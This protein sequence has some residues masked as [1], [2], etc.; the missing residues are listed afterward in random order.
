LRLLPSHRNLFS[1]NGTGI[2]P[3]Q[4]AQVD[5]TDFPAPLHSN[6]A[7]NLPKPSPDA[8][9]YWRSVDASGTSLSS[10][11]SFDEAAH[12][13][14]RDPVESFLPRSAHRAKS[15]LAGTAPSTSPAAAASSN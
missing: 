11:A 13:A 3:Q 4:A 6:S 2:S 14:A 1:Y 8:L 15:I 7:W 12:A 5:S 9:G 10:A